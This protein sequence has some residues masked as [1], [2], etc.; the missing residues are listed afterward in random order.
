[1][2]IGFVLDECLRGPLWRLI[3]EHNRVADGPIDAVRV[4]DPPDLPLMSA[5]AEI[6]RWAADH[7][8]ILVTQDRNTMPIAFAGH[9]SKGK[10]S[11]GM[12]LVRPA[13]PWQPLL[14]FLAFCSAAAEPADFRDRIE[15]VPW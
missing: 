2:T 6:V 10:H 15:F 1:M 9:L 8:R 4:G 7:G 11:P 13:S 3:R 12:F 5:D 14:E